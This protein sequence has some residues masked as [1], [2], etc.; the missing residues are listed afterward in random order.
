MH[1]LSM[2]MKALSLT[3][4]LSGVRKPRDNP[5]RFSGFSSIVETAN[6]VP[7][8]HR[9]AI[10]PL[11]GGVKETTASKPRASLKILGLS[12]WDSATTVT[13]GPRHF[14]SYA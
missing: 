9:R 10:T 11:K 7:A 3:P 14:S 1:E 13:I 8:V 5:N 12:G 2:M 6:A 4:R